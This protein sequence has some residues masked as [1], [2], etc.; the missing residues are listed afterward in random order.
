VDVRQIHTI[1]VAAFLSLA[2]TLSADS[3]RTDLTQ[4]ARGANA[5]VV[6]TVTEVDPV[7]QTNKFGDRLIVSRTHMRVESVL[8]KGAGMNSEAIVVEVEGGT[9]GD[10]T[11]DV[12]DLPRLERGERA[13]VFLQQNE[14]GAT[15]PH[16]RGQG[17]LKLDRL[18]RVE[19]SQ[20]TLSAIRQAVD[21]AR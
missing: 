15:T 2:T 8:K 3:P 1:V 14:R 17:I 16:G 12:S 18:D 5:V 4:L 19:G 11:L 9:I 13:V 21:R 7:F 10:L 20:L 6:A